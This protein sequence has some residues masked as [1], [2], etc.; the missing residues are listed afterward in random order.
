MPY[1]IR[2]TVHRFQF[3]RLI[4]TNSF[5]ISGLFFFCFFL[6]S[7]WKFSFKF[8]RVIIDVIHVDFWYKFVS[9]FFLSIVLHW[10]WKSVSIKW[11]FWLLF[12]IEIFILIVSI[13][14]LFEKYWRSNI[15]FWY[16]NIGVYG[17][18][19]IRKLNTCTE[20]RPIKWFC[21]CLCN[22]PH[23]YPN[24]QSEAMRFMIDRIYRIS[25]R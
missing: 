9:I 8:F 21:R 7:L 23:F 17:D 14:T 20:H 11:K 5:I 22:F 18:R 25:Y 12:T 24:T 15:E 4:I 6:I 13:W 10:K 16:H 1:I 19:W 3:S 2:Y